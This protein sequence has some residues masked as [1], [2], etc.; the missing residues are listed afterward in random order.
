MDKRLNNFRSQNY[1]GVS[2]FESCGPKPICHF[3]SAP[4]AGLVMGLSRQ[5]KFWYIGQHDGL[6]VVFGA[7]NLRPSLVSC[8]AWAR[9][10][11]A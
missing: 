9:L 1:I 10:S 6:R 4:I 2:L 7:V 5:E 8:C 11:L 3:F